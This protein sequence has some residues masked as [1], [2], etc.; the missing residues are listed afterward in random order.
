MY[1][2]LN[3]VVTIGRSILNSTLLPEIT[4]RRWMKPHT[5]S[6]RLTYSVGAPWEITRFQLPNST[7]IVDMYTKTGDVPG[8]ASFLV[9]IPA[10]DMGWTVLS[11]GVQPSTGIA[12]LSN[13]IADVLLPAVATAAREEASKNFA[14]EYKSS[15]SNITISTSPD[16]PGLGVTSWFANNTN[17]LTSP[18]GAPSVRLYPTGL[19][20]ALTNGDQEISFRA[21][22]ENP[23]APRVGGVF[24]QECFSWAQVDLTTYG[25]VGL[26]EFVFVVDK[27]GNARS[28]R[29]RAYRDELR[30]GGAIARAIC[31]EGGGC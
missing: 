18:S 22:Y 8:Y 5:F 11:A 10:W 24:S 12:I 4:T 19:T 20:R 27:N 2:T 23:K 31:E 1:S 9:L 7:E 3:E 29:P 25:S 6:S 30:R 15:L 26:D 13:Q 21:V 17:I 28:V 16:L 14:G